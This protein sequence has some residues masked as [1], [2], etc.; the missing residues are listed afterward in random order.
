MQQPL[1]SV[2]VPTRERSDT[3]FYTLKTLVSQDYDNLEII[4][5]DNASQDNTQEV[6]E[7]FNDPR[8]VYCQ[9][10]KRLGMSQ[11]WEFG[12]SKIKGDFL[13]VIGDDDGFLPHAMPDIATLLAET[14][15]NALIWQKASYD[16]PGIPDVP[17][18]LTCPL[19]NELVKMA[20]KLLLWMVA[21]G[22]T[23][24]GRLPVL[25]SGFVSTECINPVKVRTGAFFHSNTPDVYSGIVLANMLDEYLYSTRPFS[26][27]GGSKHSNGISGQKD[28]N[29]ESA[30]RF[31]DETEQ[32]I[33]GEIP[34]IQGSIASYVAESFLQA[35]ERDLTGNLRLDRQRYHRQIFAELLNN[36]A[37]IRQEGL[38]KLGS[39]RI[40]KKLAGKVNLAIG[41]TQQEQAS[42]TNNSAT[43]RFD[44]HSLTVNCDNFAISD[45]FE[46]SNLATKILGPYERPERCLKYNFA[47]LVLRGVERVLQ[48][49]LFGAGLPF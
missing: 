3:L 23:S 19:R 39:L 31:F 37:L 22:Y 9:T 32:P 8:V 27:N 42:T 33:H 28:T 40:S 1:L 2:L 24:Y 10:G 35:E 44:G 26:I 20:P 36:D 45:V 6:V 15:S 49:K 43:S 12:L 21:K 7:S 16:W 48:K 47:T 38:V 41:S 13:S 18:R 34:I 11:N 5:S 30:K 14:H 46:A 29:R 25:Y 17:H 4:V